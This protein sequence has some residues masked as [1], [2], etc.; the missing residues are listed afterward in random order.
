[1]ELYSARICPFAERTRLVL[2]EKGIEHE[3]VEVDLS[4]KSERFMEVS[5][6]GKV[7][8]IMHNGVA[9]YESAIINEYLDDVFPEPALS[10]AD[11]VLRARGRIWVHYCDDKFLND[12]YPLLTGSDADARDDLRGRVLDHF[13]F[14]DEHGLG[15]SSDNGPY[16]FGA[17]P[18][19]VD[20]AYFPFFERLPAW[21][22]YR[23]I[24]IPSE[25]RRLKRWIAAMWMRASVQEIANSADYYV[26]H[27]KGYA[28]AA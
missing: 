25:C 22:H 14:I 6:Y 12:Y 26:E 23:S 27:Y 11:P 9:L 20:F 7:P 24:S 16:W 4:D 5:P 13:H 1:M 18:T 15:A 17:A 8:A 21:S 28:D 3:H 2:V 10:P 19:L